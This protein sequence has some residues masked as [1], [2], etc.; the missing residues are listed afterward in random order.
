MKPLKNV[1]RKLGVQLVL[2]G[3]VFFLLGNN[4]ITLRGFLHGDPQLS[5]YGGIM[6]VVGLV[7]LAFAYWK[8]PRK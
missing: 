5:L 7:L 3:G 6:F 1:L 2:T 8:R 4:V